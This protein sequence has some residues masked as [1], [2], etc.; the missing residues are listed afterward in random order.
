GLSVSSGSL[1][2]YWA[3]AAKDTTAYLQTSTS[4][5]TLA[6]QPRQNESKGAT[7]TTWA[8][9]GGT[10]ALDVAL[11]TKSAVT[12]AAN[13]ANIIKVTKFVVTL[14][15]ADPPTASG[16]QATTSPAGQACIAATA[17]DTG[18]GVTKLTVL[19]RTGG[20]LATAKLAAQSVFKPGAAT[21][22]QNVC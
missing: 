9:P 15:D 16:V 2:V 8:V 6:A 18:S 11:S 5:S 1:S 22:N 14:R 12:Y 13:L 10:Q 4:P 3:V 20:V 7:S 19:N 17:A 21:V